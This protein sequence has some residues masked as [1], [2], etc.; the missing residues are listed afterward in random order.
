MEFSQT[1]VSFLNEQQVGRLATVSPKNQ[2][3]VTP[4]IFA[5]HRGVFYFTTQ[6]STVKFA[7]MKN[8]PH[9][10]FVVD[11]YEDGG[12]SRKA[13]TVQGLAEEVLEEKEFGEA[14]KILTEKL[15][16][17]KKNPIVKGVNHLFRIAPTR[18]V[19]WGFE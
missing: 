15:P 5:F 13:I 2:A 7:N 4:I 8:N 10:G 3:Q 1:E 12:K 18:K 17:Y 16:Y 6:D 19:S 9:V 11:I 14:S